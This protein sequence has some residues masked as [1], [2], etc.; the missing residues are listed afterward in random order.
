MYGSL[1]IATSGLI[2]QRTRLDIVAANVA[3]AKN[4]LNAQGEYDPYRRRLPCSPPSVSEPNPVD[5]DSPR[6]Q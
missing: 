1:D 6:R 5:T 3:N 2:A 4:I